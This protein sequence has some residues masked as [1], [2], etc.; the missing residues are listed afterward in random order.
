MANLLRS[1]F[2]THYIFFLVIKKVVVFIFM[3]F[4]NIFEGPGRF[5]K[6]RETRGFHF[7][8]ISSKSD[9]MGPSYD[10][11]LKHITTDHLMG[12]QF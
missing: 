7:H 1:T 9:F 6:V 2:N 12:I 11:K 10:P 5:K 3:F 8:I 4:S